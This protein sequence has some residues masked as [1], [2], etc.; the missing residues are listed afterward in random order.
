MKENTSILSLL[1][2]V[3][4][5]LVDKQILFWLARVIQHTWIKVYISGY[6]VPTGDQFLSI[7]LYHLF[8]IQT[9]LYILESF[10]F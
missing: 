2:N 1:Q 3:Q 6:L 7:V 5:S 10:I 9:S 4:V 8:Y